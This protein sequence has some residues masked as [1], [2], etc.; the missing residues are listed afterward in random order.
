M[1]QA[2]NGRPPSA[3]L[4]E[5][6]DAIRLAVLSGAPIATRGSKCGISPMLAPLVSVVGIHAL[7]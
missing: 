2:F 3:V 5:S 7:F 4:T 6:S 1:A